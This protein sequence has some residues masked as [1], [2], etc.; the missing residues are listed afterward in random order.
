MTDVI[1]VDEQGQF[2]IGKAPTTPHDES[3]GFVESLEDGLSYWGL[4]EDGRQVCKETETAIYTGTSMLN[5]LINLSGLKAG[6]IVTRG[7]EDV[8]VQGRG[9]QTFI[10]YQWSE[11]SH[12]QYRKHRQPLVPRK[13]TRGVTERIDMFGQEVIP[14]YEHEVDAA[15]RELLAEGIESLAIVFLYSFTNPSHERRAAEIAR[16]VMEDVGRTVPLVVSS[17]VAPLVREVSRANATIIQA[18][19]AEPAR[20]QL[21]RIEEKLAERGYEHSLKTVLCYGG[22][23]NIRYQRLFE[24]VMSGP[25]GGIMGG[26]HLANTVGGL[27]NLVCADMGGTSF[28]A[29]CITAGI[30]PI[31]R[32]PPFQQ[33]YVNVPMLDIRSIGAGTGTY[34]RLDSETNRLKLGPDSAGGTPG[35]VFQQAGNETPTIGDCDLILGII[36]EDYYLGGRIKVHK[37]KA[38]DIFEEKIAAPLGLDVYA[39]AEQCVNLMNV[40]MREHLVRTLML[41]YDIRDY[42]LLGYGG[43]G[44]MHLA[45]YAS[46]YPWKAV[47]TVPHAAAFSAWG[48]ACMDYAHRRHK[49]V[50]A[51]IPP[52]ADSAT[53]MYAAQI[54]TAAWEELEGQLLQELLSEG[55]SRDQISLRQLAYMKYYGHL[56][57]LEVASPAERLA[58]EQDV[59]ALIARFEDVFTKSYTLAGKPP[60][61]TYQVD[62]VSVVAQVSTV[63]PLVRQYDLEGKKPPA[64]ASKGT[65]QAYQDGQWHEA[66]LY[67][68]DELRPGNE[69]SGIAVIEAPSTTLFVPK[70]WRARL[71]EYEIFWLEKGGKR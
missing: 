8:V 71:D 55:F 48:G 21:F 9:S 19:A 66:Q 57:D 27:E 37:Q 15:V 25:V 36:N 46:E 1:V 52:G 14:V 26:H 4:A 44:P 29:G 50:S 28:D 47:A 54:V 59:D 18:Y 65:R 34:I 60:Y 35:P 3:I 68:M 16:Q 64:K 31:N 13:L 24:T 62:E 61:A 53:K 10:G 42:V 22:V 56:D 23:T 2:V 17:E 67:E 43:A 38:L 7:F 33:M 40:M 49:S 11:I 32:E 5:T 63:K 39:A 70:G 41:G 20:N 51:V 6:L 12:M 69:I 30:L 45:G 58:S